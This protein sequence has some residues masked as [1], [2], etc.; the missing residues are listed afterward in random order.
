MLGEQLPVE[1]SSVKNVMNR[2]SVDALAS[3]GALGTTVL[4]QPCGV[5]EA[6]LKLLEERIGKTASLALTV[7]EHRLPILIA[8]V[9]PDECMTE[10]HTHRHCRVVM[11][12]DPMSVAAS[13]S[14]N[15]TST[16]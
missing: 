14:R 10:G 11:R 8:R 15:S 3:F 9:A 4:A 2:L 16:L 6:L 12:L 1:D 13:S 7:G 5:A